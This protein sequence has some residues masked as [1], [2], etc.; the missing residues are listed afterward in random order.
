MEM[1]QY[2][3]ENQMEKSVSKNIKQTTG[4]QWCQENQ[5]LLMNQEKKE[6]LYS[7]SVSIIIRN[8]NK[9]NVSKEKSNPLINNE[10]TK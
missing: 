5:N 8:P 3:L 7:C 10:S 4:Y 6:T 2:N 1:N 9:E